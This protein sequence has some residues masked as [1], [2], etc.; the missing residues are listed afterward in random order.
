MDHCWHSLIYKV[1][2]A[3]SMYRFLFINSQVEC[4][5]IYISKGRWRQSLSF[6]IYRAFT[7]FIIYSCGQF[8]NSHFGL[9][10]FLSA[11]LFP[12]WTGYTVCVFNNLKKTRR[13]TGYYFLFWIVS[14]GQLASCQVCRRLFRSGALFLGQHSLSPCW[15]KTHFIVDA[16]SSSC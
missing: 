15:C 10:W 12:G 1:F 13:R 6:I 3:Y 8:T 16:V 7:F 2:N 14:K 5:L 4:T 11:V 9:Q